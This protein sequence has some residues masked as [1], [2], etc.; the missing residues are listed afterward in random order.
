MQFQ[1]KTCEKWSRGEESSIL[2]VIGKLLFQ[3]TRCAVFLYVS[4]YNPRQG[5][6]GP[7]Q[8]CSNSGEFHFVPPQHMNNVLRRSMCIYM[9]RYCST[10]NAK[11]SSRFRTCV[12]T[13]MS[14]KDID[15]CFPQITRETSS[16]TNTVYLN[17]NRRDMHCT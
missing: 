7:K 9:E 8:V 2:E 16:N 6:A 15:I 11:A 5:N 12:I 3:S 4:N 17:L 14:F 1:I 13:L 10:I